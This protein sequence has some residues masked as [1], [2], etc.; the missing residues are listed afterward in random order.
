MKTNFQKMREN[1][2]LKAGIL[3]APLKNISFDTIKQQECSDGF[4]ELMDNRLVMG[5]LRYGAAAR[6]VPP[7]QDFNK[8]LARLDKYKETGNTELLVDAAN[9]LRMEFRRSKHPKKH[10]HSIDRSDN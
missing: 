8:A 6:S 10:F 4:P 7:F 1:L 3:E 2:L 9:Y 5:Y